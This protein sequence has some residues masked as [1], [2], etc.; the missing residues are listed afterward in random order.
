MRKLRPKKFKNIHIAPQLVN[1]EI[2][3][4]PR[5]FPEPTS[6]TIPPSHD[7]IAS[8]GYKNGINRRKLYFCAPLPPYPDSCFVPCFSKL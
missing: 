3:V 8:S 5:Q 2:G 1:V 7:F 4:E 6:F